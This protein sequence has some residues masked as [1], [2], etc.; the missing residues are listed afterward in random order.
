MWCYHSSIANSG[1]TFSNRLQ[2]MDFLGCWV[3]EIVSALGFFGVYTKCTLF[4][5]YVIYF[6]N[7]LTIILKLK[8]V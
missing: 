2:F 8:S 6:E 4:L 3:S 1:L 7:S 5:S